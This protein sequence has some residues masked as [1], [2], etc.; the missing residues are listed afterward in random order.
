M[1]NTAKTNSHFPSDSSV[2]L[3]IDLGGT[4]V[5]GALFTKSGMFSENKKFLL[6]KI[7]ENEAGELILDMIQ[8]YIDWAK[9]KQATI[10]CIGVS[11]PGIYNQKEG[12]VWAPNIPNWENYPLLKILKEKTK[13]LNIDIRI[14]SD[15]ACYIHGAV[16]KGVAQ[17]CKNAIFLAVG[18]GIG[19]GIMIDGKVLRGAGD[20][21]GAIGWMALSTPF[22]DEYITYGC[23]ESHAS[24][25]G[26]ALQT[27]KRL[28]EN[29]TVLKGAE[30][31]P[32]A[33]I[34]AK[35]VFTAYRLGD[36]IATEVINEAIEYWGKAAA[37]L[38]SLFNPEKIIFG[39]GVFGPA[40]ELIPVIYK[41]AKKWGQPISMKSV[42]FVPSSFGHD[43]GLYGAGFLSIN[44][45]D[46]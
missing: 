7:A 13:G 20:I 37:N 46:D 45:G 35:D 36:K 19:A 43:A 3:G 18:T 41:E 14:D 22:K 15:R 32:I 12:T 38:V 6:E 30:S 40:T 17:D 1:T 28:K 16:W 39:G 23:F 8:Y 4:K 44:H 34:C 25:T 10:K 33:D 5:S 26:L 11:V 27:K 2:G 24:G 42:E 29:C 9:K 31:L 21:A